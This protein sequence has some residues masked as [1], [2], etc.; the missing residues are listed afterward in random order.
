MRGP[1]QVLEGGGR[2]AHV[3]G[4]G[5]RA[6]GR[7]SEASRRM[8][9]IGL[10]PGAGRAA[11]KV[12]LPPALQ[13]FVQHKPVSAVS[14]AHISTLDQKLRLVVSDFHQLVM[15]FLQ[16]YD[17][18]LGECCKRP[19]P[20]LHP[21]GPIIQAVYQTLTSCNQ[22]RITLSS[23]S[24]TPSEGPAGWDEGHGGARP[25]LLVSRGHSWAPGSGPQLRTLGGL[26]QQLFLVPRWV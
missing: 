15:A 7:S 25:G 21:C 22:V 9:R 20:Y 19:N 12:P 8:E 26:G 2:S 23:P 24:A 10:R 18:E 6:L 5:R 3:K 16:V 11:S 4:R 17:D 1:R 13:H 14:R